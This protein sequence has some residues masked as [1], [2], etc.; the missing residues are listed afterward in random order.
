MV[1]SQEEDEKTPKLH[2]PRKSFSNVLYVAVFLD[3]FAVGL[4]I[5]VYSTIYKTLGI[6]PVT[7]GFIGSVYGFAQFFFNPIIGRLSDSY[8]RKRILIFS[9]IGTLLFD[10]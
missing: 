6:N 10:Y 8:G 4:I 3:L 1:F 9:F 5:P 2:S 7:F